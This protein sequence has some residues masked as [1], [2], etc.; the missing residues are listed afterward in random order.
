MPAAR[1]ARPMQRCRPMAEILRRIIAQNRAGAVAAIPSVCSA[2]PDVLRAALRLAQRLDRPIVIEATSNQVNQ[3]GGYTG[4]TPAG[5]ISFVNVLADQTK[6]DR[7]RIIFGGD[8]LGPQAWR[9]QPVAQA[10]EK[11]RVMVAAYAAAGFTKIH[12]DCSEGCATEPLQLTDA[13][14]VPRAATLARTCVALAPDTMFVVGTEVPPPGGARAD[15]HGDIAPTTPA[16]ARA[17]LD[18]HMAAFADIGRIGGL[19]VQPGVEFS[20][21]QVH[22]LPMA[23]DPG[24]RLAVAHHSSVTLEAHSTDYQHPGVFPRLA[25]LGFAFQKVGPALTFAWRQAVYAL[26]LLQQSAGWGDL[27]VQP[28]MERL[29]LADPRHWQGH[30]H[31]T[32][33]DQRL[34]RHFGLA[35]RIRYYWP[36]DSAVRVVDRLLDRLAGRNLPT[37]LLWQAFS[38]PVLTL[39]ETIPGPRPRAL[40]LAQVQA[41]LAPYFFGDPL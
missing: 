4:M 23:R 6:T 34:M 18:A 24:L 20:P 1:V 10:M 21:M 8:H 25:E 22:P 40:L 12:L 37:P 11:A 2:H 30:Y 13:V 3:D 27:T 14:T 26:D 31:G 16:A 28:E 41:A 33:A 36:Q 39:A 35:D 38:D 17:T 32:P 29:M 9:K 15:E 7:T 19:V 5:F